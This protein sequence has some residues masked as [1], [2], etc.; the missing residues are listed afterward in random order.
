MKNSLITYLLSFF[1]LITCFKAM[2]K[3]NYSDS[4]S[5]LQIEGKILNAALSSD[6][7]CVVE[8][9]CSNIVL[10]TVTLKDGKKKFKFL[11]KKN[12]MYSIRVSQKGF[13]N[14]L[15]TVDTK[16]DEEYDEQEIY[17]F[18]FETKLMENSDLEKVKKELLDF[19]IAIIYFDAKKECFDYNKEYTSKLKREL[20][21]N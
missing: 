12:R 10:Q 20:A 19:P 15:I 6:A 9:V 2:G 18:S 21:M 1:F 5:C 13:V 4:S 7:P 11:L 16:I 3:P 8:L 14:K 17:Q